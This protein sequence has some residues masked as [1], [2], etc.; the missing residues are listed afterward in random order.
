MIFFFFFLERDGQDEAELNSRWLSRRIEVACCVSK[1]NDGW[2]E[3]NRVTL[4]FCSYFEEQ[5]RKERKNKI[6]YFPNEQCVVLDIDFYIIVTITIH[7]LYLTA[8]QISIYFLLH[9]PFQ[10]STVLVYSILSIPVM[11]IH[12]FRSLDSIKRYR[13]TANQ[14]ASSAYYYY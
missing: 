11:I 8:I 10:Q 6:K 2:Q 9:Y 1:D 7:I 13:Q 3:G 12:F 5:K 14:P 4:S